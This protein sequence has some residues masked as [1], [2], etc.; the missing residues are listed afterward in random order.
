[1]TTRQRLLIVGGGQSG[2][3]AARVAR[4]QGLEPVILEARA[5]P[6]GAWSHYYDS[7][8]L[9]SPSEHSGFPDYGFPGPPGR[10]PT[11][12]EVIDFLRGYAQW[13]GTEVRT[14]ATV[15]AVTTDAGRFIAHLQD[16][17]SLEGEAL[18]AATGSFANPH[19]PGLPG[20]AHFQGRVL[21]AADYRSPL[22]FTGQRVVVVGAGNSAVQI[23]YELASIAPTTL[24]TRSP[25]QFLAQTRGGHDLHYWFDRLRLD[26]LPPSVLS[27]IIKAT[28]VLDNGQYREAVASGLLSQRRMFSAFTHNGVVWAD[29][30]TEHVDTVV[31][32]TGYRPHLPYLHDLGTLG[33]DGM[34]LHRRGISATHPGLGYLGMEFQRSFSSNT[35]RGVHRDADYVVQ[36]LISR[37]GSALIRA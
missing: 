2:L 12:D 30:S 14:R 27:R 36:A 34:P 9:F 4:D 17:S 29:G 7:L 15:T 16:G 13:L 20:D 24:A 21:H 32:A 33:A 5:E 18:V 25:V 23:G 22:P 11:K 3:A 6:T 37:T 19:I 35:L 8:T 26:L 28:P 1:M 10:Y 31:F